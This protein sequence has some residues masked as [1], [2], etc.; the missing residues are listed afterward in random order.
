MTNRPILVFDMDGV[1]V[2]VT[3]SYR[4]TIVQTVRHFSG[5]TIAR[6]HIQ[7]YKNAGG[8]NND[9]ALSQ[10]ILSDLG[11]TVDY[12]TV[13]EEFQKLFFGHDGVPGLM[14]REVWIAKSDLLES[15][16]KQYQLAIFTGRL[17][18]EAQITLRR[19]APALPFDPIMA[20][21]DVPNAKPAPDGLL[22]IQERFPGTPLY[23]IG[24]TVDD[25]NASRAANVPFIGVASQ[26]NPRYNDLV[27]LLRNAGA[28]AIID[29]INEL[30]SVLPA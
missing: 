26:A 11:H 7:D 14:L 6:D 28:V 18:E 27:Q 2:E 17:H 15:L 23:Y 1:L 24:D 25:A 21:D 12:A 19:F 4:E 9:W 20:D 22:L 5:K 8:W 3:E 10:K 13:V 30:P 16:A 29:N